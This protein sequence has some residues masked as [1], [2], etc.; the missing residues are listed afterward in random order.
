VPP[1]VLA[2][3]A[4]RGDIQA[5]IPLTFKKKVRRQQSLQGKERYLKGEQ[6][7]LL[8]YLMSGPDLVRGQ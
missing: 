1:T 7:N 2:T 8:K 4:P 3:Q 5:L 6:K